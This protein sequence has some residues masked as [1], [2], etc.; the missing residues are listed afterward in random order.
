MSRDEPTAGRAPDCL[1][2][3]A[4]VGADGSV[5]LSGGWAPVVV[6]ALVVYVSGYQARL[7]WGPCTLEMGSLHA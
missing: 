6:G 4:S 3:Y 2:R 7:R 5:S 1:H